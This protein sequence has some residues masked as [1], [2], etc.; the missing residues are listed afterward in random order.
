MGAGRA[1]RDAQAMLTP[2]VTEIRRTTEPVARDTFITEFVGR[3][4]RRPGLPAN[5]VP[6]SGH[7]SRRRRPAVVPARVA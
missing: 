2:I 7:R 3:S 5:V 1:Q 6:L 4:P